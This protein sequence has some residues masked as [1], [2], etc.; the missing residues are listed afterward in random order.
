MFN[1]NYHAN[2]IPERNRCA[3]EFRKRSQTGSELNVLENNRVFML[4]RLRSSRTVAAHAQI[5]VGVV[6][7]E[8]GPAAALGHPAKEHSRAVAK[9]IAGQ[10][11]EYTVLDD[12]TDPTKAVADARKLVDQNAIESLIGSSARPSTSRWSRSRPK[13]KRPIARW[14][15]PNPHVFRRST[16]SAA[17][18]SRPRRTTPSWPLRCSTT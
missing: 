18:C 8:T 15:R 11:V 4:G 12:A 5:H 16:T 7:S 13:P 6:V 10:T 1:N 3:R 14:C 2:Q 9:E 17:G